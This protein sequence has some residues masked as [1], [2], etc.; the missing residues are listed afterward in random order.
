MQL[1]YDQLADAV[2][3]YFIRAPVARTGEIE[4]GIAVDYD[5]IGRPVGVEFLDVSEGI[6]LSRVPRSA[7]I[8]ELLEGYPFP[9][10]A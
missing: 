1:T 7:E 6:D 9:I 8:A 5:E 4:D 2:Y 3:V 10:Y